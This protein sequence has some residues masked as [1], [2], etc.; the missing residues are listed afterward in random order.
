MMRESNCKDI[1]FK[2]LSTQSALARIALQGMR[3]KK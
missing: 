2:R 1:G 3:P